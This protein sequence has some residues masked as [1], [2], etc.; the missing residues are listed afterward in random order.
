MRP[1]EDP[2]GQLPREVTP[3]RALRERVIGDLRA[4]G[5]L[6]DARSARFRGGLA[7]A[8]AVVL[9]LGGALLGRSTAPDAAPPAPGGGAGARFVLLLYEGPAYARAD[10]EEDRVAEYAAWARAQGARVTAGEKLGEEERM[11]GTPSGAGMAAPDKLAGFFII[12][13]AGW[14]EAMAI[15]RDCPHLRYGGRVAVREIAT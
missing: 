1:D 10:R 14:D 11:L 8:A 3:P 7:A 13:A 12:A 9:F 15:A 2:I 4:R 6:R 5:L